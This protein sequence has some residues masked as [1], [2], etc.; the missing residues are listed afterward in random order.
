MI[1]AAFEYHAPGSIGEATA[2]LARLGEDAKVLSGG[3]SRGR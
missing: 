1:P 2:L 3:Q